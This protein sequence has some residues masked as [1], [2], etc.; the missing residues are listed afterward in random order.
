MVSYLFVNQLVSTIIRM[1]TLAV[2]VEVYDLMKSNS[3]N[4]LLS[5]SK[6]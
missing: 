4:E 2:C 3:F 6:V 5:R 1:G